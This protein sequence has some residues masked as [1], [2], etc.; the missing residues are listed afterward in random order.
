M[1]PASRMAAA[2]AP[3]EAQRVACFM[4]PPWQP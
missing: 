3:G 1:L 2:M 4:D